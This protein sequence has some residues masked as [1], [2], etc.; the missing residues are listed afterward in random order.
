M[1]ARLLRDL[2]KPAGACSA[3]FANSLE[4][5]QI[6]CGKRVRILKCAHRDVLCGPV[7]DALDRGK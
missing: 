4:Q 3:T 5:A 2:A 6:R 7:A 1:A